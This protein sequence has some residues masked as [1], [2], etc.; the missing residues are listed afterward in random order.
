LLYDFKFIQSNIILTVYLEC[1]G[2]Y[3]AQIWIES[4][5]DQDGIECLG[6]ALLSAEVEL[7]MAEPLERAP[8]FEPIVAEAT[9]AAT[10]V[11]VEA[12]EE[13]VEEAAVPK[14]AT[15]EQQRL[16]REA[17]LKFFSQ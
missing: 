4:V 8:E 6:S 16:A 12:A 7:D 5:F 17:R 13:A 10:A 11:P 3:P 9:A 2:G 14:K 15:A 1:M